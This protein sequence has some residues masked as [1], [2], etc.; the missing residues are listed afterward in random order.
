MDKCRA[1]KIFEAKYGSAYVASC[2]VCRVARQ[3][4][5]DMQVNWKYS[6]LEPT[7]NWNGIYELIIQPDGKLTADW[8]GVCS[9]DPAAIEPYEKSVEEEILELENMLI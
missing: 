5:R 4:V 6:I 2:P 1:Q 8:E 9:I 7:Q 3:K